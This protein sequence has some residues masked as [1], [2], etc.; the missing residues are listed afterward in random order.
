MRTSAPSRAKASAT[1]RPMP[2]VAA[3]DDR[4]LALELARPLVGRPRRSPASGPSPIRARA[5]PAAGSAAAASALVR[6]GLAAS[7]YPPCGR[8]HLAAVLLIFAPV[9]P[10]RVRSDKGANDVPRRGVGR[11]PDLHACIKVALRTV[12]GKTACLAAAKEIH[13]QAER[14]AE[15]IADSYEDRACPRARRSCAWATV[16]KESGGGKKSGSDGQEGVARLQPQGRKEGRRGVG[17]PHRPSSA[18]RRRRRRRR[19]ESGTRRVQ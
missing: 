4:G 18:R 5:A 9:T 12:E 17:Q 7:S 3:G 13:R 6:G 2:A 11:G 10:V 19:R 14:K 8:G 1:A 15:H 16:N